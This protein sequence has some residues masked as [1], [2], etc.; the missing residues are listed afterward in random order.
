MLGLCIVLIVLAAIETFDG[1]SSVS[2]LFGDMSESPDQ[3]LAVS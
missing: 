3:G 2:I 1:L